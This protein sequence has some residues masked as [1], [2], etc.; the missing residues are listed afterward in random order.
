[1]VPIGKY[2]LGVTPE[3]PLSATSFNR[4]GGSAS[5][6]GM[7]PTSPNRSSVQQVAQHTRQPSQ[8]LPQSPP[9]HTGDVDPIPAPVSNPNSPPLR[10]S[11][12]LNQVLGAPQVSAPLNRSSDAGTVAQLEPLPASLP[13]DQEDE[14]DSPTT[15]ARKSAEN[16][17]HT[18]TM[19]RDF[20]FP[21]PPARDSGLP[22]IELPQEDQG[23]VPGTPVTP[24]TP[25]TAP[26][27]PL[28]LP[29]PMIVLHAA[30]DSMN[31]DPPPPPRR[32]DLPE[33]V[34][35]DPPTPNSEGESR[36]V[37]RLGSKGSEDDL[38]ET[39]EVDLS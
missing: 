33:V 5:S 24:L 37:M 27:A 28:P 12:F 31:P 17:K 16:R 10:N 36:R 8:P 22:D 35:P 25:K 2:Y 20:K 29:P 9:I 39:V 14:V 18:G 21:P 6:N 23:D 19:R 3:G 32:V 13:S 38:G 15:R 26:P 1:M 4:G 7:S 34:L 30:K 11:P